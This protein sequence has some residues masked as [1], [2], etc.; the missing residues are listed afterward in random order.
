MTYGHRAEIVEDELLEAIL[1]AREK[2]FCT[3][4]RCGD[5][6]YERFEL[7]YDLVCPT[8]GFVR[9]CGEVMEE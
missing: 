7:F 9:D 5:T 4:P 3:C 6:M 8:C 2:A 1:N